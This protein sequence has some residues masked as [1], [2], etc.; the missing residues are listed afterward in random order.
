LDG[1]SE[2]RLH[3]HLARPRRPALRQVECNVR[4][5]HPILGLVRGD[6]LRHQ[7]VDRETVAG[8]LDRRGRHL[9]EA[10]GAE[11]LERRDPG[12]GCRRHHGAQHVLRNLAAM[13]LL[14]V[15]A[16][17]RLR[18]GA[19]ARDRDHAILGGG[20]DDDRRHA[21]EVHVFR[22]HDAER[23]AA[24][25]AGVD[26]VAACLQNPQAGFGGEILAGG[27][28]MARSHD[29]RAVGLHVVLH[30]QPLRCLA[31]SLPQHFLG[32]Q[33]PLSPAGDVLRA[34]LPARRRLLIV[35][36]GSPMSVPRLPSWRG[37]DGP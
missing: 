9:A 35:A 5:K 18:P 34:W 25:Y 21:G 14:E 28:H 24:R 11:A 16:R 3:E 12:I 4:R 23:D 26:G 15:V 17:D 20:I 37:S 6:D 31:W 8:E 27:D 7:R 2:L 32:W 29:G 33:S 19:E 1:G 30:G 10:H 36:R 13:V 22:L